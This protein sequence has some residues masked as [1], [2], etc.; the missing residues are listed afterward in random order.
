[1]QQQA[2]AHE[3]MDLYGG[4]LVGFASQFIALRFLF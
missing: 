2:R 3:P 4:Y 1:L